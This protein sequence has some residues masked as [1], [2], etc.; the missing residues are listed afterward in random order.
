L[1]NE[2]VSAECGEGGFE[3][4]VMRPPRGYVEPDPATFR[5][6]AALFDAAGT[7]MSS[8]E[9]TLAGALPKEESSEDKS[10]EGLKQGLL[11][12]LAESAAKARLFAAIATK[13]TRGEALAAKEYEEILLFGRVAEHHF[14]VFKSLANK[15]LALSTPDPMPKIADVSDV[16]GH[17]PYLMVGVGRP[18]EWDHVVP[19]FGRREVVKGA[20]Y[21]FYEFQ[22]QA[23]LDDANWLK[24]LPTEPHPK[25]VAPF[26]SAQDLSCPARA[27]F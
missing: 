4:I 16:A 25:W 2:R 26:V 12:R 18:L 5:A 10:H 19:Y 24:R 22:A 17:A 27:P 1:V 3:E 14:L 11:R 23:L 15:D 7:L 21:S 20:A 6:I 9:S 13:E 8:P